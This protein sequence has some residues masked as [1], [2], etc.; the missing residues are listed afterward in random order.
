MAPISNFLNEPKDHPLAT[1]H[2]TQYL[3]A[4][5][6]EKC[7]HVDNLDSVS[8]KMMHDIHKLY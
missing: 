3:N 4:K 2:S 6:G 8:F 5:E 7:Y 1:N